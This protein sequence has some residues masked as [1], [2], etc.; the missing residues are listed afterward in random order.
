MRSRETSLVFP[1]HKISHPFWKGH[2]PIHTHLHVFGLNCRYAKVWGSVAILDNLRCP[3]MFLT[4][5]ARSTAYKLHVSKSCAVVL[6]RNVAC[7]EIPEWPL[8]CDWANNDYSSNSTDRNYEIS[9][10]VLEHGTDENKISSA[11]ELIAMVLLN[12]HVNEVSL[13]LRFTMKFP[14]RP[15]Q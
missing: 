8:I 2:A 12:M 10:D 4:Y 3:V 9:L 13:S 1:V 15:T 11:T 7:D 6:S 5:A 14:H